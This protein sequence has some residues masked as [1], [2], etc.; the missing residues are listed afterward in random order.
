MKVL[1]TGGAG[2]K[3]IQNNVLNLSLPTATQLKLVAHPDTLCF[4]YTTN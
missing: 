2:F 4:W 3:K 1:V